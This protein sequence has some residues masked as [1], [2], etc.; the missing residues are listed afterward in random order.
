MNHYPQCSDCLAGLR[1]AEHAMFQVVAA[2]IKFQIHLDK[3][4]PAGHSEL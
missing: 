3:F 1:L 4:V 2:A